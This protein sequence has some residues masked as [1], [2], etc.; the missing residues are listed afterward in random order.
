MPRWVGGLW[1]SLAPCWRCSCRGRALRLCSSSVQRKL[2]AST[3]KN[4]SPM[5][6]CFNTQI[7]CISWAGCQ[8]KV[9]ATP[10][11]PEPNQLA[12]SSG[13]RCGH[14]VNIEH[15][16]L[17]GWRAEHHWVQFV[18]EDYLDAMEGIR[19]FQCNAAISHQHNAPGGCQPVRQVLNRV[20]VTQDQHQWMICHDLQKHSFSE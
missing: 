10:S 9:L 17:A 2:A 20:L 16:R 6:L 5:W 13:H 7:T 3:S 8:V 19:Q 15:R 11:G 1:Y 12:L 4:A 18:G 14:E